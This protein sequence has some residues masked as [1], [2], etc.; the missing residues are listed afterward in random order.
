M[1]QQ[2]M[3]HKNLE[4]LIYKYSYIDYADMKNNIF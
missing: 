4:I 3:S 2:I 1:E